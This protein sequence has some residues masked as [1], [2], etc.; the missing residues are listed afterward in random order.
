M[1]VVYLTLITS[2]IASL[3][4]QELGYYGLYQVP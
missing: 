2:L 3:L 4:Y 1:V